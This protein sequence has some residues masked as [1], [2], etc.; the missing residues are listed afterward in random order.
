M[1]KRILSLMLI[2]LYLTGCSTQTNI[3]ESKKQQ[4]SSSV[5]I[6]VSDDVDVFGN[7]IDG[8][9]I[10]IGEKTDDESSKTD[11]FVPDDN[12]NFNGL[13]VYFID[14]GQADSILIRIDGDEDILI[15][16]GNNADGEDLVDYLKLLGVDDISSIIATHPHEDHIG[17]LDAIMSEIPTEKVYAPYI[18][19]SDIPTTATY[20]DFLNAILDCEAIAIA[21]KRGDVIYQSSTCKLE[22]ISPDKIEPGDLNDYSIVTKLTYGDTTFLFTGDASTTINKDIMDNYSD[23]FLDIDILKAGH[24]GSRTA[25]DEEWIKTTTPECFVIMCEDGNKYG[26]P[27]KECL[28]L[29]NDITTYRTDIDGT[30]KITSDGNSY[31]IETKLTG[32]V[33]L[34]NNTFRIENIKK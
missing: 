9:V 18:N 29:I 6:Y 15:D 10:H 30:V 25:I 34:G 32:D 24:H 14:V 23:D 26:H 20:K 4:S 12:I 2:V 21:P 33:P 5:D 19:D 17:G 28:N 13:E 16:G 22:V 31:N 8:D 7:K 1:K 3:D 11:K 27:H